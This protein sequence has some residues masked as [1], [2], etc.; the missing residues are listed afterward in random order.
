MN[1]SKP[2]NGIS[3]SKTRNGIQVVEYSVTGNERR[4]VVEN[5]QV[6]VSNTVNLDSVV[7]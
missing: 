5:K 7:H 3:V 1:T 6:F 2:S 4:M